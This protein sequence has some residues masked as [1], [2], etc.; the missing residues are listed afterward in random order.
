[1]E[2]QVIGTYSRSHFSCDE[3]ICHIFTGKFWQNMDARKI[4]VSVEN[5]YRTGN[6]WEMYEYAGY[7]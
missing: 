3:I 4:L 1:M 6:L 2:W 5:I 7:E